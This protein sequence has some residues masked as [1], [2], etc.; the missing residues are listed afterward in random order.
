MDN[1]R[2]HGTDNVI[3]EYTNILLEVY[4]IKIMQHNLRSPFINVIYLGVWV[5]LLAAV[6]NCK[7]DF[8]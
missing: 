7:L 4:N 8:E 2:G 1:S 6:E 3:E 5:P